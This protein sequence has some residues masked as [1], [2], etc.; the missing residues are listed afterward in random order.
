MTF[1]QAKEKELWYT[2]GPASLGKEE[3]MFL[4]GATGIRLTFNFG[5]PTLQFE[6]AR[7]IKSAAAKVGA[8]CF[9]VAD[10]GGEKFRLGTFVEEPTINVKG[11][12]IVHLFLGETSSPIPGKL[13]LPIPNPAFL[14]QLEKGNTVT[15]GDGSAVFVV[16]NKTD[17]EAFAEV[18]SDGVINNCRGLTIEGAGF[19]PNS[20]TEKDLNDLEH[21]LSSS[22]YDAVAVSFVG[23][24]DDVL[25]VRRLAEQADNKLSIVAK[26][27]TAAGVENIDS[28][29]R[30]ADF[31]MAARGDL[32]VAIPWLELP[33]AVNKIS[34][35]AQTN[36]KPWILATQ[37]AEGLERF[38]MPTRAEI[39]DLAHWMAEGCAGTLLS[40]ETAFG[41]RPV[42]AVSCVS[43]IMQRWEK[44]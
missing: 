3:E 4:N 16:T 26:I 31:I 9:V 30:A 12:D 34:S 25:R 43:K 24:E 6:R 29:T 28:I 20:L 22:V 42:E 40:Y 35:S 7:A 33:E 2:V 32:A 8:T 38:A 5:T 1:A 27:E 37:I 10:L 18:V 19:Q 15:V 13:D 11:G 44:D 41:A 36:S 17:R 39:C 21:I 14:G 23:S